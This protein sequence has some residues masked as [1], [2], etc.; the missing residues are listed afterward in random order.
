MTDGSRGYI[1]LRWFQACHV[2]MDE[3]HRFLPGLLRCKGKGAARCVLPCVGFLF[4]EAPGLE[5]V[6]VTRS[7]QEAQSPAASSIQDDSPEPSEV[8]GP[9]APLFPV[10]LG[11]AVPRLLGL[12][13][14]W[15][16]LGH[17]IGPG[18]TGNPC[19]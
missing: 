19:R 16:A 7:S 5:S 13:C 15:S 4:L 2:F 6:R 12:C 10:A 1:F 3:A 11:A 17:S 8:I 14:C 18:G 9:L